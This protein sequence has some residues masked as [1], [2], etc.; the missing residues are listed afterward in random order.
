MLYS[1]THMTTVGVN[2]LTQLV[3][4]EGCNVLPSSVFSGSH[5]ATLTN[6]LSAPFAPVTDCLLTL[7]I[8][9]FIRYFIDTAVLIV[10]MYGNI[11]L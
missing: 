8:V 4:P 1:C 2:G 11:T 3:K 6:I 5:F 10:D 7:E 9:I